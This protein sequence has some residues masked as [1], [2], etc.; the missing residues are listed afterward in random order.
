VHGGVGT[1]EHSD[2][3]QPGVKQGDLDV[4]DDLNA[5]QRVLFDVLLGCAQLVDLHIGKPS[6]AD[7]QH[8]D[9]AKAQGGPTRNV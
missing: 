3:F 1:G 7:Q 4:I 2:A 5:G 8:G 6:Q 9:D